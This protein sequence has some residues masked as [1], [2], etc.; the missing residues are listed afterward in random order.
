M[1]LSTV[2]RRT[3]VRAASTISRTVMTGAQSPA[4]R[5]GNGTNNQALWLALGMTAMAAS[6][7]FFA[8]SNEKTQMLSAVQSNSGLMLGPTKE[9]ST[10]ILFPALCNGM[11]LAGAGVRIK[12]GL[13]KVYAVGT[14]LD[15]VAMMAVKNQP[16]KKLQDALLDP[17][18]PRVIRIV[19]A[20][21]LSIDKYNQAIVEALEPKMQGQDLDK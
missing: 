16:A 4:S 14:Y 1:M 7:T 12:Y 8:T 5:V 2:A 6:T 3:G 13:V 10:G 17:A 15:P 11:H 19:M 21:G 18:Y 9:K 20:R